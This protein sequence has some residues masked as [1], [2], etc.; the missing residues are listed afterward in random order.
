MTPSSPRLPKTQVGAFLLEA[1]VGLLIFSFGI[2]GI[3]ALQAQSIRFTNDAEIR[4]EVAYQTN[5]LIST[6]W[7]KFNPKNI[8]ALQAEFDSTVGGPGYVQFQTDLA[9]ALPPGVTMPVNPVVTVDG[10]TPVV[11][12]QSVSSSVVFV[13]VVWLMPG[14]TAQHNYAATGVIGLN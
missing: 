7:T 13:Q 4:A 6:M 11:P 1:L 14:D 2:L 8:G 3:V 10:A 9:A 5:S 12:E